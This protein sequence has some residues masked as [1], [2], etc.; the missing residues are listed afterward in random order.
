MQHHS[1]EANTKSTGAEIGKRGRDGERQRQKIGAEK[2][3]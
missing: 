1:N 2:K 3:S